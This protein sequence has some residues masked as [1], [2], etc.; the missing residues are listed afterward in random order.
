M[1]V[2]LLYQNCEN[3]IA[4]FV[5]FR[6]LTFHENNFCK[7]LYSSC[8]SEIASLLEHFCEF[9]SILDHFSHWWITFLAIVSF[10][11]YPSI[12]FPGQLQV[13]IR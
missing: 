11:A 7:H 9:V 4:P 10:N 3:I 1:Q 2:F 8:V 13:S 6:K 12:P 5:N